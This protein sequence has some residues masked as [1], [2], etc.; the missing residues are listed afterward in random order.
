MKKC[1]FLLIFLLILCVIIIFARG[2]TKPDHTT[3]VKSPIEGIF[4]TIEDY[5]YGAMA[6]NITQVYVHM[7]HVEKTT[8][9]LVLE[10]SNLLVSINWDKDDPHEVTFCIAGY[11]STFKNIVHL[12]LDNRQDVTMHH[13]LKACYKSTR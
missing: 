1:C 11:T 7:E 4:Y 10:G 8:K 2:C 12:R 6:S 3:T 9:K 5:E 13:S